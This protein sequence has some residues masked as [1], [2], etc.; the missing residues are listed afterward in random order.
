MP[1]DATTQ[2]NYRNATWVLNTN[3]AG[4][5]LGSW[6][7]ALA[8]VIANVKALSGAPP[9]AVLR[10]I[11]EAGYHSRSGRPFQIIQIQGV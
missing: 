9:S 3:L 2:A 10:K 7:P 11:T 1:L 8:P 6:I 4:T 5:V